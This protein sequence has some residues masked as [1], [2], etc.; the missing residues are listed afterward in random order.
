MYFQGQR[1]Y[2]VPGTL[3]KE[4]ETKQKT[5]ESVP[6]MQSGVLCWS[7]LYCKDPGQII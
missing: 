7:R 5:W 1:L 2:T 6:E 4:L 3:R